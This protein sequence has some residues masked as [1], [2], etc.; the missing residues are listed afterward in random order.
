MKSVLKLQKLIP[1]TETN[2]HLM[3]CSSC[4]GGSCS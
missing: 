3:S 1:E 2:I 4:V